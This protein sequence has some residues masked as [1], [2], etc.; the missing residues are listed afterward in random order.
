[1]RY[2]TPLL[3]SSQLSSPFT[4]QECDSKAVVISRKELPMFSAPL[5]FAQATAMGE[6]LML[7]S[8]P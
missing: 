5:L 6:K 8:L 7:A 2:M 3:P 1:M 4:I